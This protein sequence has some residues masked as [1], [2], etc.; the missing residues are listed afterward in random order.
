[1]MMK[2]IMI[3]PYGWFDTYMY[4]DLMVNNMIVHLDVDRPYSSCVMNFLRRV[5]Y[6]PKINRIVNLPC[7]D[8]WNYSLYKALLSEISEDTCIIFDTGSLAHL[9][10]RMLNKIRRISQKIRMVLV[11]ADSLHGASAHISDALPR[12]LGFRWDLILSYDKS[13]CHEFG[14]EYLGQTIYS[15]LNDIHPS[16]EKSDLYFI[17]R[18]KAGRNYDVLKL[19]HALF[20][21]GVKLNFNLVDTKENNQKSRYSKS[22]GVHLF[23]ENLPYEKVIS[24]VL[25][26]KCILE[27]VAPGQ[28]AQTARYYEAVCYNKK[29]L[30]NNAGCFNLPFYNKDYIHYFENVNDIN[31]DWIKDMTSVEYN[32]HGEFSPI[33]LLDTINNKL[34]RY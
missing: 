17:G 6:S 20:S 22:P 34:K 3:W 8:I 5:H 9:S 30:T 4:R 32:Y 31:P 7:K 25:S 13:D 2:Y 23:T 19:Y 10:L 12:I 28:K 24:D 27:V 29:L 1:M 18:N 21:A 11:A 16:D 15:K 26:T 33:H 14:F